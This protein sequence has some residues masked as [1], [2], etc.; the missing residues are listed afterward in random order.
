MSKRKKFRGLRKNGDFLKNKIY[1]EQKEKLLPMDRLPPE[2]LEAAGICS[3]EA[4]IFLK[5]DLTDDFL[6]GEVWLLIKDHTLYKLQQNP[7]SVE[8]FN[9]MEDDELVV[10]I[11]ATTLAVALKRG[12]DIQI[13]CRGSNAMNKKFGKFTDTAT[14]L[15]RGEDLSE[16]LSVEKQ[17]DCCPN[18]GRPYRDDTH[19]CPHCVNKAHIFRR[20][21]SYAG[22]YR[23]YIVFILAFIIIT[24]VFEVVLPYLQGTVFFDEV[25]N[26]ESPHYGK[27]FLLIGSLVLLQLLSTC[28][29]II[30]GRKN[31]HFANEVVYN[32]R[33]DVF[34]SMQRLS[35]KYFTDK[36]TG[37]L[38]TRV[39]SDAEEV[40]WF[41]LDGIPFLIV[42][43]LKLTGVAAVMIAM[44]PQL[45]VLILL[46]VPFIILFFRRYLPKFDRLYSKSFRYRSSMTSRMNDSFTG[47]R[48]V[49][50]FGKE[51][52]ENASFSKTS[53]AFGDIQADIHIKS[54]TVFPIVSLVMWLGSL[55]I[56]VLGGKLIIDGKM[57]FGQ[58]TS[59]VGYV[60]MI[61]GP[62]EWLTNTVQQFASAMNSANRI[63][64]IIDAHSVIKEA[65]VPKTI[66]HFKGRVTFENVNFSYLPNRPVLKNISFE[67]APG[68]HIGIVGPSGAGK[69]TL[70]NLI[71]RLYDTESGNI[72]FDGVNIK[73][74]SLK[75]LHEQVGTVL[76]DTYLFMGTV[77]DNIAYTKPSATREEVINAAK[78]ADA[79]D[80]IMKM[81]DGYDT[82]IGTGGKGLSGGERQ[83]ISLARAI[84]KNPKILILDEA[85]SAVDTQTELHIQK[86]LELLSRGR[87]TFNIAHRLSTLR[88]ADRLVVIENGNLVEMG[89]HAEIYALEG[90]YYRLYQIQK[91]ALKMRGLEEG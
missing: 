59:L 43:F 80:F 61:Y 57:G 60:G 86:A 56:Y 32:M 65:H 58:L 19:I 45:S 25:L 18:C 10:E 36:E 87:T 84:L 67:A 22:R 1:K 47:V 24:A 4:Q 44:K 89:T 16:H 73:E 81:D 69:S 82:W 91:D 17:E 75:W 55:I 63:F 2:L 12:D 23:K 79:H 88:N 33:T 39:N 83:R 27:V 6:F 9:L 72:Y 50:A 38:M 3:E 30:Y 34:S 46:P 62:L 77:F 29:T 31:S 40:Q 78:M 7:H 8:T 21:L 85:T 90:V 37:A 49:K 35:I 66:E 53:R 41:M 28:F 64:E 20:L 11:A 51:Q 48:V 68:E 15:L 26:R 14:K 71:A 42:N 76:Q 5:T 52:M 70:I 13:I 74:L 54:G